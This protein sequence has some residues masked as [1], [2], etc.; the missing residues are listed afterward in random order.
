VAEQ[1]FPHPGPW[2]IALWEVGG[3]ALWLGRFQVGVGSPEQLLAPSVPDFS[4]ALSAKAQGSKDGK[5][6]QKVIIADC[7]EYL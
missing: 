3:D 4:S 7:G 2:C 6:K 5:P 1:P